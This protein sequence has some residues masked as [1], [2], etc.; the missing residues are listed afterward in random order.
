MLSKQRVQKGVRFGVP[1]KKG[2]SN[3]GS[4]EKALCSTPENSEP[5]CF[6]LARFKMPLL[7]CRFRALITQ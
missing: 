3:L 2:L 6:S 7:I 5:G 4:L 1:T